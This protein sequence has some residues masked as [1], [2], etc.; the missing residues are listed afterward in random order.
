MQ[1]TPGWVPGAVDRTRVDVVLVLA[2]VAAGTYKVY[3]Y[4][5]DYDDTDDQDPSRYGWP[6]F[7][8]RHLCW[9]ESRVGRR[10]GRWNRRRLCGMYCWLFCRVDFVI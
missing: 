4:C 7:L 1:T 9:L 6:G 3:D 10:I 2:L 5:D 8:R